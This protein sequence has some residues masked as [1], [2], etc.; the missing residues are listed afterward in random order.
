MKKTLL[1]L[2][3][4][5]PFVLTACDVHE[6][7]D[8]P[9]AVQFHLRLNYETD[10]T[11]WHHSYGNAGVVEQGYGD[12]YDNHQEYGQIR[13]VVRA[14]PVLERNRIVQDY[15]QEFTFIKNISEGYDHEV[16][17]D[18]PAGDY[19][20]MVWSDLVQ[21]S[22]QPYFYDA[23]NFAEITFQGEH[24]AN[25]DHRDAFRG[26]SPISLVADIMERVPDTLDIAMQRP[27]AKYEFIT[28][29][30]KEFIDKEFEFL[31]REAATRGET[32]PTRVNLNEYNLICY[33]SGYMPNAYNLNGDKPVDSMMGVL[34]NSTV[35]ILDENEA[36]L[37]FDYVF[38]GNNQMAV[39]M[40]IGLYD[41]QDRQVALTDPINVPLQRSH[42]TI[43]KGSF[44]IQEAS[45][46]IVIRPEFDGNHNIIID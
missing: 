2:I 14:Y 45:G 34:F 36:S 32:P 20:I 12:T 43:L 7:P 21:S 41:K 23:A 27:L 5:L 31:Q 11:V 37:G 42:H 40:Q 3:L 28:T 22:S 6:W 38:V 9:E 33:Y 1:Y 18:L 16:S 30:L 44:L 10:I 25:T 13:Y 4:C 8:T 24:Q 39:T 26:S 29:D 46:G 35:K 19:Q 17:L 15:T